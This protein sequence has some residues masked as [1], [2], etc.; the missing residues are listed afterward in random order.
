MN[1]VLGFLE[2]GAT[3]YVTDD[4]SAAELFQTVLRVVEGG[5]VLSG[6]VSEA[7]L[8]R[9]RTR[10]TMRPP[11][12]LHCLTAREIEVAELMGQHRSNKEMGLLH[13]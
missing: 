11:P 3:G 4:A 1:L 12:T 5:L 10:S 8:D 6:P 13:E 7:L 2:A 9:L